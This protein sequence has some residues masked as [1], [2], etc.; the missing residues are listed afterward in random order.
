MEQF[1]IFD[2]RDNGDPGRFT[3]DRILEEIVQCE[4]EKQAGIAHRN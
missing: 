4:E 3:L 1:F 2:R